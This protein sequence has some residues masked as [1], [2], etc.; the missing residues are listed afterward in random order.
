[1]KEIF[2][3]GLLAWI[4][5]IEAL[6]LGKTVLSMYK[7]TCVFDIGN[8]SLSFLYREHQVEQLY[9]YP[10]IVILEET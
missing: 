1:M 3:N 8:I 5:W 10:L 2:K 6:I 4:I 9:P 7:L